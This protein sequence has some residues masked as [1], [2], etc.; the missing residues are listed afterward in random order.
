MI[1]FITSYLYHL[2]RNFCVIFGNDVHISH[3]DRGAK[4]DLFNHELYEFITFIIGNIFVDAN[5]EVKS[6]I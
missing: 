6:Y 4:C 5:I 3:Y 1:R 2:L